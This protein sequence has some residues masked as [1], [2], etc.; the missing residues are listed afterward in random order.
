MKP[1]SIW[2]SIISVKH[3][4]D[5]AFKSQLKI[6]CPEAVPPADLGL[7]LC[8]TP[9]THENSVGAMACQP[10]WL[11]C[12]W[13]V[14][15]SGQASAFSSLCT[16]SLQTVGLQNLRDLTLPWP[17]SS[18]YQKACGCSLAQVLLSDCGV[19]YSLCSIKSKGHCKQSF[20][21]V[22]SHLSPAFLC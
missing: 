18:S 20:P 11:I 2:I 7:C 3:I 15:T 21:A 16:L 12:M 4:T 22:R 14:N 6:L 9:F 5:T 19:F 17:E 1:L 10:G 8:P 13:S